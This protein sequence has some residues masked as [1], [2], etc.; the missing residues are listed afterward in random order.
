MSRKRSSLSFMLALKLAHLGDLDRLCPRAA[1][2]DHGG[3]AVVFVHACSSDL[4]SARHK[5]KG[6]KP[7]VQQPGVVGVFDVFLHQLPVARNAL[8]VVAQMVSLRPLNRRSKYAGWWG[9]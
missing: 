1:G 9:P 3:V 2:G 7:G 6:D 8:A 4:L 5:A